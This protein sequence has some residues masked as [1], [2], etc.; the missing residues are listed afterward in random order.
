MQLEALSLVLA[1]HLIE[2]QMRTSLPA[3]TMQ[4]RLYCMVPLVSLVSVLRGATCITRVILDFK[5]MY[6]G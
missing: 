4:A 1:L 3:I 5:G 2:P 6:Q